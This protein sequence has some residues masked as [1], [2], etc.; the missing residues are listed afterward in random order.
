ML[1]KV[2]LLFLL[3]TTLSA[4][5]YGLEIKSSEIRLDEKGEFDDDY[6]YYGESLNFQ[7][8]VDDLYF[9]GTTL[10][11]E[12]ETESRLTALGELISISGKVGN[13]LT[14]VC[15]NIDITGL[16]EG[17]TFIA[18]DHVV[19]GKEGRVEGTIFAAAG[20][21]EI[22]GEV[23]GDIYLASGKLIINGVVKGDIKATGDRLVFGENGR[24]SGDIDYYTKT[25]MPVELEGMTN[26][27]YVYKESG[28]NRGIIF[29]YKAGLTTFLF[30]SFILSGLLLLLLPITKGMESEERDN[31]GFWF[32]SL[33]GLIPIFIYPVVV[34]ILGFTII[35]IPLALTL[36]A[37]II[38]ATMITEIVGSVLVGRYIIKKLKRQPGRRYVSFLLGAVVTLILS[39]IPVIGFI[40]KI[41]VSSL[42]AGFIIEKA[43]T[44][45]AA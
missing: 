14:A 5:L 24:V 22:T 27:N 7:G 23:D 33:W 10:N 30:F 21:F 8:M 38:P 28:M 4:G 6:I 16:V 2:A 45:K 29:F 26:L 13:D 32:L 40:A 42:G 18:A 39:I 12:G 43:F 44:K 25:K 41:F 11:I 9:V 36:L 1:K 17:T 3:I 35:G 34:L 15:Q 31:K 19:I 20:T 37:A